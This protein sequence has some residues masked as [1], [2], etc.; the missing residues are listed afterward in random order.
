M[1][2]GIVTQPLLANYGG[3][4][5]NYALQQV[6]KRMGHTPVTIDY[7]PHISV[8]HFLLSTCKTVCFWFVPGKRRPFARYPEQ[9][10]RHEITNGFVKKEIVTTQTV[11][12]YSKKMIS[13]NRFAALVVGSD[14]VWRPMYNLQIPDMFLKFAKHAKVKKIAYAASFGV[15]NWEYNRWQTIVSRNLVKRFNAVSVREESGVELCNK[16]L[17]VDAVH[18]LDPTLLLDKKDYNDLCSHIPVRQDRFLAAY[19][20]NMT[21]EKQSFIENF[22]RQRGLQVRCF[23]EAGM[24]K[25]GDA[26]TVEE[27]LSMFRDADFVITDSFH[28]SVFSIIY[29]KDFLSFANILRGA[30]RFVSL[31]SMFG[32]TDRI[33]SAPMAIDKISSIVWSQVQ[34]IRHEMQEKSISFIDNSLA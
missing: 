29:Q 18:L 4:L 6:L 12:R 26:I 33:I 9:L 17:G 22:A 2:I 13:E 24:E 15:D 7:I 20:L 30:D 3:I 11:H 31:L 19:I 1:K 10:R 32:L 28:G 14:Q 8:M 34:S 25:D 21:V 23:K 27:W 16:Y 5:Q